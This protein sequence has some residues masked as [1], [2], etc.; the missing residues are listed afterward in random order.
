VVTTRVRKKNA[1]MRKRRPPLKDIS[2]R[3]SSPTSS[4]KIH[5]E[6]N[7]MLSPAE[8]F[9]LVRQFVRVAR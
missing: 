8:V 7:V 4:G 6:I 1:A 2:H 5:L 3:R 9:G